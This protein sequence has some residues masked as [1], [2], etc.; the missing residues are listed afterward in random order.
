VRGITLMTRIFSKVQR[1]NTPGAPNGFL[2]YKEELDVPEDRA[3]TLVDAGVAVYVTETPAPVTEKKPEPKPEPEPVTPPKKVE[4][5]RREVE[6]KPKKRV[7]FRK[8]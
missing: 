1:L 5:L 4:E 8:R 6:D 3:K 7:S 2:A